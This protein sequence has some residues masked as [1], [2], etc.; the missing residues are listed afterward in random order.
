[1][2]SIQIRRAVCS[3]SWGDEKNI[4]GRRRRRYKAPVA[5]GSSAH[6]QEQKEQQCGCSR[7]HSGEASCDIRL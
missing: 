7:D 3:E 6:F 4:L 1:M 2:T 5:G